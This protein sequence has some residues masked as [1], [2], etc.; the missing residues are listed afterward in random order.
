MN[1]LILAL[2]LAGLYYAAANQPMEYHSAEDRLELEEFLERNRDTN[3]AR[4][5]DY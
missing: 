5:E 3:E 1:N 2:I 4:V